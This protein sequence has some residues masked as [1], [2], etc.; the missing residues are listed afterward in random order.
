VSGSDSVEK[1]T[2][3]SKAKTV[4]KTAA[5]TATKP[6]AKAKAAPAS[7]A[8]KPAKADKPAKAEA[9]VIVAVP[10]P[11]PVD[12]TAPIPAM[13]GDAAGSEP[14]IVTTAVPVVT[15]PEW[16]KRDLVEK[17]VKRSGVKKKDVKQVVDAMLALM[18][19]ALV[20]GRELILQPMGRIKT[21]RI[22]DSGN[23]RVLICKLRQ[24]GGEGKG[25]KDPLAEDDD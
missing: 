21:T 2:D 4:A 11:P 23:G 12:L 18:G 14:K 20:E 1:K 3:K 24:G 13:A 19:E 7:K 16:K 8:A 10:A 6:A 17:V 15:G 25:G 5:K 9:P 22:K